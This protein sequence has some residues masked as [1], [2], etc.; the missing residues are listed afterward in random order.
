MSQKIKI[1]IGGINGDA[2]NVAARDVNIFQNSSDANKVDDRIMNE[3]FDHIE[4]LELQNISS[5]NVCEEESK[6]KIVHL[7]EKISLNFSQDLQKEFSTCMAEIW[8]T[9]GFVEGF[10]KIKLETE[11]SKIIAIKHK[12]QKLYR[13]IKQSSSCEIKVEDIRVIDQMTANFIPISKN[14]D[15]IY[16]LYTK[17]V[18]CYFFE[19][20]DFGKKTK[21]EEKNRKIL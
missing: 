19:L 15:S 13:E 6:G 7:K 16:E 3:V 14:G 12:I 20:C 2:N 17:A 1:D 8:N 5:D 11:E 18:I 9:K 10:I 4:K 21:V